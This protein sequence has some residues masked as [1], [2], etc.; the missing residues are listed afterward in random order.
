M[1]LRGVMGQER[2]EE[3]RQLSLNGSDWRLTGW[4]PN[5]WRPQVSMELGVNLLPAV[6]SITAVVP[7][8]VQVDLLAS[9]FLSDIHY[10]IVSI[11]AEWVNNREWVYEKTFDI[12]EEWMKDRC[13]AV[14]E[15][16]DYA[17]EIYFNGVL[18][19]EFEGMFKPVVVDFSEWIRTEG[20]NRLQ[21]VFYAS[22][23]VEGQIGYSNRIRK[24]KSRF[25]YVWDWCPRIVP[26]GIWRDVYL[27]TFSGLKIE[28]F[29]P[30]AELLLNGT[31]G[32]VHIQTEMEVWQSGSYLVEYTIWDAN[33]QLC[34]E[35][36]YPINLEVGKSSIKHSLHVGQVK[37]W[38][39]IGFGEHRL[40]KVGIQL[41]EKQGH[42]CDEANKQVG[43]RR[44]E[45]VA[46]QQSP[47]GALPYTLLV[48]GQ[49]IFMKGVNWVPITPFYGA[50]TSKQYGQYLGRFKEMNVNLLRVWGGGTIE[51]QAFYDY[52]DRN[53][54]LVWQEFPQSSSGINNEPPVDPVFL[55]ELEIVARIAVREKRSHPS[56]ILWCGG[57]E[58]MR[59]GFT[60]VDDRQPNI[61][62]LK[63]IVRELDPKRFFLPASASGPKFCASEEDFGKGLH[64]DVHGPWIY[65]GDKKHY[66]FY[67]GD[68]SLLRS[69]TGTASTSRITM[70]RKYAGKCSIW[71]PT[72][73]NPYWTHRGSWWIQ[74]N[75]M[76]EW[77]GPWDLH[78]DELDVYCQA[79]RYIQMESLRYAVE[80][81]RRR[82]P[83]ASGFIVW[84]GNEPFPNNANTSIIEYD[85]M[86]K[87]AY[88][89]IRQ[90]FSRCHLSVRYD[91]IS[92]HTG[93]IFVCDVF[94]HDENTDSGDAGGNK[95]GEFYIRSSLYNALGILMKEV[96]FQGS[97]EDAVHQAG[98]MEWEV[99]RCPHDI[100]ILRLEL[101]T[102]GEVEG[103]RRIPIMNSYVYTV[104]AAYPL[105]PL[106]HLPPAKIL[107][108]Q[109][110]DGR[111]LM[112]NFSEIIG[113]GVL[114]MEK[115]PLSFLQFD[116]NFCTLLPGEE[117]VISYK[118]YEILP[119]QLLIEGINLLPE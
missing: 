3:S 13:E 96:F 118:P 78:Q 81:T 84:M 11:E 114:V 57:N 82:E 5:Q 32:I 12:P 43:F 110:E 85:G 53:G 67:N 73:D 31:E 50:V 29:Y 63:R 36:L 79:S 24:L 99:E 61:A 7:G 37:A 54:L 70:L 25:N 33:N 16:L 52:C 8:A 80:S 105:Q 60:P 23:E 49:R 1:S 74:W 45:F 9:G 58:L 119:Q 14:F 69:E 6:S 46:N 75:E 30:D 51:K 66:S 115:D 92:F 65:L 17:G 28:D 71:P 87:P 48:N 98:R 44:I 106:R 22:P 112:V 88:Y 42:L 113:V 64:H 94:L 83:F 34:C 107:L 68:D 62:M 97:Y 117:V 111:L 100:F 109:G 102:G 10:G 59:E 56:L 104:D 93:E 72:R 103:N 21:V 90:A 86:P 35:A 26:V 41:R 20:T 108:S 39:P 55:A 38:W 47:Q 76:K 19:R 40:Y 77:F 91:R 89:A 116:R 101:I 18:V 15:G 4:H 2:D 27:K 95:V